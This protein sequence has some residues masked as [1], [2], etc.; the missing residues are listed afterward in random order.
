MSHSALVQ[1]LGFQGDADSH[2]PFMRTCAECPLPLLPPPH[3]PAVCT[4]AECLMLTYVKPQ[5]TCSV[6]QGLVGIYAS[7]GFHFQS[8]NK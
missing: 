5:L 8:E 7:C 2:A 4:C 3:T 6:I 1:C